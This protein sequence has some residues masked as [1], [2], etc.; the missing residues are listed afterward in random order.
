M[1][2]TRKIKIGKILKLFFLSIQSIADLSY[3][4]EKLKK[5]LKFFEKCSRK[6]NPKEKNQLR[7]SVATLFR[8]VA[9]FLR[10]RIVDS[11]WTRFALNAFKWIFSGGF[12]PGGFF[13]G[14][15]FSGVI[16]SGGIL[17]ICPNTDFLNQEQPNLSIVKL[18]KRVTKVIRILRR[19]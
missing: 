19:K 3:K 4:F 17:S 6:K 14:G 16:F 9:R 13:S 8:F 7:F 1:T 5:K 2:I 18:E 11:S 12:F 15:I 10:V